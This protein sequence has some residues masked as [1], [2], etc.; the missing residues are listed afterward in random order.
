PAQDLVT[1]TGGD[2]ALARDLD[3]HHRPNGPARD[4]G[5]SER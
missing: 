1:A 3:G 5:A 4:A 2:Y